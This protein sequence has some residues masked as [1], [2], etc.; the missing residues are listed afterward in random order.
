MQK[1]GGKAEPAIDAYYNN[2]NHYHHNRND[3]GGSHHTGGHGG[4]NNSTQR[5]N[6]LFDGYR[7]LGSDDDNTFSINGTIKLC[8]DLD[9]DPEDVVL[10][11]VA[12][13]LK[14]PSVGVFTRDG[15]RDGWRAL[16]G[17]VDS[18]PAMKNALV[19]LR[20]NLASDFRYFRKV[21]LYTFDFARNEGQRSL[22]TF[23]SSLYDYP[24]IWEADEN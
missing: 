4:H 8:E 12:Y 7:A 21:Y 17:G 16:G 23:F 11:A 13:E 9:V 6:A 14:A 2:N 5:L 3:S 19:K 22:C 1:Y 20:R 18:I 15:W 10:L 24:P